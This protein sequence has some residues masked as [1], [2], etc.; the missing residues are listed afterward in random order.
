MSDPTPILEPGRNC[1]RVERANRAAVVI[2]AADYYRHA[3]RAM[4][5][6]REQII[7]IGWDFDTRIFLDREDGPGG[8]THGV[9]NELGPFIQWLAKHRP[10]LNIH[11]LKWDIGA[12]KLL[13]RGT[14]LLRL[15]RWM[16]HDRI[17]FKL[18]GAHPTGAS[19]HQ[20]ILVIDDALA[21][22]GG[23]D[24][25]ADRWD[26][27]AH[28]PDQPGRRRPT[29][30]RRYDPWHDATM[31][32]DGA[33]AR[34]LGELARERWQVAGGDPLP[35]PKAA[36]DVWPP[37]LKPHFR[38]VSVGIART[39]GGYE[40]REEV[41]ENERLFVDLIRS[42]ERFVY[43]ENQ[44][45][46]SRAVAEAIAERLKEPAGPEFVLVNPE[47]ADGW[48]EEAVMG[49]ARAELMA[50]LAEIDSDKRFRIY[51]P[52][53][54]AGEDI[55]VHA[56]IMVVDDRV[57]RVGSANMNNRSMGLDSECDVVIDTGC[58]GN[59]GARDM[60]EA[61]RADLL[62]EHLG[63]EAHEVRRR[64]AETSSLIATV[65]SLRGN[66][67]SLKTFVP[68]EFS[69]TAEK[70]AESETL[71]PERPEGLFEPLSSRKLLRHLPR[72]A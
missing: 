10:G 24:M 27:R 35:V 64:L 50:S 33:A 11:I 56:K 28:A 58:P 25:T 18:D 17:T 65:E 48:L 47:S 52:V 49:P 29:T 42:A 69:R 43:A 23:I 45:F 15:A 39:R 68:P 63:A 6:A 20:K 30:R 13:G 16:W 9:P 44:Y 7:L 12:L 72:P 36:E 19:H 41:R 46:A 51:T 71:D 70:I 1:W 4:L 22:C 26:T 62:A 34:A 3:K 2:D 57:L 66:G 60:I 32:L 5:K 54:E 37:E 61:I 31:A 40:D 55:Y 21:F 59:E 8:P 53:N 67:R 14:T 38:D